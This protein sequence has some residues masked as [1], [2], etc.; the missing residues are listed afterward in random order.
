VQLLA[1]GDDDRGVAHL[2]AA[3]LADGGP[4]ACWRRRWAAGRGAAEA[5]GGVGAGGDGETAGADDYRAEAA[6]AD[7]QQDAGE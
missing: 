6:H 4:A 7:E 1:H 2:R 5:G 3:P